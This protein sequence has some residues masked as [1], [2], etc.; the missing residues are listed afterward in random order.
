MKR[1]R[2]TAWVT[3][4]LMGA[5]TV[6]ATGAA[7]PEGDS[8]QLKR[9]FQPTQAD[10]QAE[11]RGRVMIYDGLTDRAVQRAFAEQFER[12]DAMMFTR[13]VVTD[14]AGA[15]RRDPESGEVVTEEDGCD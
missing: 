8:W 6:A 3:A 14:A 1:A 12:L 4:V 10:L 13:T 5:G 7:P 2:V 11:A 15:P 9:L